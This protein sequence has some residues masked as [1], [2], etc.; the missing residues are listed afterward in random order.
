MTR[1]C[2]KALGFIAALVLMWAGVALLC[3]ETARNSATAILKLAGACCVW[4][5]VVTLE[6]T[7]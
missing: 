6:R 5:S 7:R 4:G 1:E 2:K 3:A